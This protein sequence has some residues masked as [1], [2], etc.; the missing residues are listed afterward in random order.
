ML[1]GYFFIRNEKLFVNGRLLSG[2]LV[3]Q[4]AI[5]ITK[6]SVSFFLWTFTIGINKKSPQK[7]RNEDPYTIKV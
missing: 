6:I 7:L 5:Y 2:S 4:Q 1:V 3:K